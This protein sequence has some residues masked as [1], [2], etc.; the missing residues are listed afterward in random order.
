MFLSDKSRSRSS[1]SRDNETRRK[2]RLRE[3]SRIYGRQIKSSSGSRPRAQGAAK[4]GLSHSK[5]PSSRRGLDIATMA[6]SDNVS[7]EMK[8]F[9]NQ[10]QVR[11]ET[12]PFR[13]THMS[14]TQDL[15]ISQSARLHATPPASPGSAGAL[16]IKWPP[17]RK[18]EAE[19]IRGGS[20]KAYVE[21]SRN[22][23][24]GRDFFYEDLRSRSSQRE[25]ER[26]CGGRSSPALSASSGWAVSSHAKE[27]A[28]HHQFAQRRTQRLEARAKLIEKLGEA[29]LTNLG[30]L[31]S[32]K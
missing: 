5:T 16:A 31:V 7:H 30:L 23:L 10:A 2:A 4:P 6:S 18:H 13:Y 21:N 28:V 20:F 11:A 27:A 17:N 3:R 19:T 8:A 9:V 12:S 29:G 25:L 1:L 32:E 22:N 26:K 24:A 14:G 15:S